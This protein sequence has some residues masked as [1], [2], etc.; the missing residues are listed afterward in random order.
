[1]LSTV[2]KEKWLFFSWLVILFCRGREIGVRAARPWELASAYVIKL[3]ST[4]SG[5]NIILGRLEAVSSPRRPQL[6]ASVIDSS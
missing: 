1:V 6:T 5:A 3:L 4:V 2:T